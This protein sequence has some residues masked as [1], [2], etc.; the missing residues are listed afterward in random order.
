MFL[1]A[2]SQTGKGSI[3]LC[4][5]LWNDVLKT[6]MSGISR[7]LGKCDAAVLIEIEIG[8]INIG[9]SGSSVE[10]IFVDRPFT[11]DV[12]NMLLLG[13]SSG[14]SV[15]VIELFGDING[16]VGEVADELMK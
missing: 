10:V 15:E 3:L 4:I 7:G 1:S 16:E 14:L 12:F 11:E 2:P 5:E 6:K 9:D 8:G 13:F